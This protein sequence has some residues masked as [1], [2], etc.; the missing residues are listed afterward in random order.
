MRFAGRLQS[1]CNARQRFALFEVDKQEHLVKSNERQVG[2]VADELI[3][4][5]EEKGRLV[6]VRWKIWL[7]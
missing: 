2:Q 7:P 3:F 1:S 5:L 4:Q 6:F